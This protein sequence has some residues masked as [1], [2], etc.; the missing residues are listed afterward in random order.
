LLAEVHMKVRH[1]A[2]RGDEA[3]GQLRLELGD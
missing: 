1:D 3:V 2:R